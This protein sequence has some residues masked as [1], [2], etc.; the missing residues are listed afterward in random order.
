M[1]TDQPSI[2]TSTTT[3]TVSPADRVALT[4]PSGQI[5]P[6]TMLGPDVIGQALAPEEMALKAQIGVKY[7]SNVSAHAE[8]ALHA[9]KS[10]NMWDTLT[11][12]SCLVASIGNHWR[13][14]SW[15][16]VMDMI[17]YA[18]KSGYRTNLMEIQDRCMQPYDALG[19]MR[20]EAILEAARG[21]E[22]LC[23]VDTDVL[24]E[25]TALLRIITAMEEQGRAMM[26]PWIVEPGTNKKLHGPDRNPYTGIQPV[27]WAVLSF[28]VFRVNVF[29]SFPGKQFWD[30]AIGSDEGYHFKKLYDMGHNLAINTD[31]LVPTQSAPTYPL[32][33]KGMKPED[34]AAFWAAKETWRKGIPDRRPLDPTDPRVNPQGIYLPFWVPNCA[35]CQKP[36]RRV[37][38][39]DSIRPDFTCDSCNPPTTPILGVTK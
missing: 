32:T 19:T 23:M 37:D 30:N 29:N 5:A 16:R 14:R 3:A 18:N 12:R 1:T 15:A 26:V 35:K 38:R 36:M 28:L 33:T 25:H 22:Y 9:W 13:E 10:G 34:A 31:V 6:L 27:R 20:N 2:T 24:P 17:D 7:G 39:P 8:G 21:Y 4:L 11:P